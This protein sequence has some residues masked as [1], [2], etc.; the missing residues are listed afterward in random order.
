[1]SSRIDGRILALIIAFAI[2]A[3]VL[4]LF[5]TVFLVR[6][7]SVG[8]SVKGEETVVSQKQIVDASGIKLN[9][10]ILYVNFIKRKR[11]YVIIPIMSYP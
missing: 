1:M 4:I 8:Y 5:A 3:V 11:K 9:K 7:I 2:I 10:N 6:D